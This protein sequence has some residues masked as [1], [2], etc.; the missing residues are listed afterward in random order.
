MN[1]NTLPPGRPRLCPCAGAAPG[2]K[3]PAKA[4][5]YDACCGRYIDTGLPAPN[6]WELMRSRYSAYAVGASEYLRAT[7]TPHTCP[8]ELEIDPAAQRWLGLKIQR[9]AELDET[10]AEVEFVA[11]FKVDGRT[12]RLHEASRF[13]RGEDGLW[14][15][16]DGVLKES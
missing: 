3:D 2:L 12:H 7:W 5:R 11:R 6:A 4:P 16:V 9:F 10:H 13:L 8:A 14:R 1:P 15:Y